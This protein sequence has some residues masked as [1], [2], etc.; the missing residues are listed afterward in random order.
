[1]SDIRDRNLAAQDR[2]G[3]ILGSRDAEALREVFADDVIDH[4]PG[5]DQAPGV[6]GIV[7]FWSGMFTAF[8][9]LVAEPLTIVAD[10]DRVTVVIDISGTH[11]GPLQGHPPTGKAF[12]ARGIQVGRFVDGRLVERWGATDEAGMLRQLGLS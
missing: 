2:L 10:D 9:D 12:R 3:E 8:P 11:T 7:D 4:D 5:P 1:M 6:Q